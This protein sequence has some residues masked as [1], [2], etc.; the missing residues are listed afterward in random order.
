MKVADAADLAALAPIGCSIQT[1]AGAVMRSLGAKAGTA[2]V[3]MGGGAVGLSAVLGGTLSACTTSILIEPQAERR[4]IALEI[5]ATHVIDPAA[6][7]TTEA[8]RAILPECA[9]YIV[10]TTGS[11]PVLQGAIGMLAQKGRLGMIGVP[12]ALDAAVQMPIVPALTVGFSIQGICEGDSDPDA[13]IPELLAHLEAGRTK[14]IGDHNVDEF[15]RRSLCDGLILVPVGGPRIVEEEL[16]AAAVKAASQHHDLILIGYVERLYFDPIGILIRQTMQLGAVATL[17]R[18][19]DV[20]SFLH[21]LSLF[22]APQTVLPH[23]YR[24]DG[25]RPCPVAQRDQCAF[26]ASRAQP[27]SVYQRRRSCRQHGRVALEVAAYADGIQSQS[28]GGTEG[29]GARHVHWNTY[30]WNLPAVK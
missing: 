18:A 14:R 15:F 25:G 9:N 16:E 22:K 30:S 28:R 19:D 21:E 8:V 20:P 26:D 7:D 6:G 5:G 13:F 1:G 4:A 29:C 27:G 23:P 3:V 2:L 10:D 17:N 12:G 11:T 24:S